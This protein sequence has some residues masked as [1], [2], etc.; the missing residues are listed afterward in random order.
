MNTETLQQFFGLLEQVGSNSKEAFYVYLTYDAVQR[1]TLCVT[2]SVCFKQ[3]LK[4]FAA[5]RESSAFE[6]DIA[7]ATKTDLLYSDFGGFIHSSDREKILNR[8][9][10]QSK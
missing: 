2:L 8:L 3:L 9:R 6:R 10:E 1:I 4:F 5:G 7:S